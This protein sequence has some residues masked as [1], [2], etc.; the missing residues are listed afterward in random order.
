MEPI[1]QSGNKLNQ[2][3]KVDLN[4]LMAALSRKFVEKLALKLN[5]FRG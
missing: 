3:D 2:I 4:K 5:P 1:D